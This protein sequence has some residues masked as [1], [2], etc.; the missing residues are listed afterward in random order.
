[1]AGLVGSLAGIIIGLIP[2]LHLNI[3]A[4][5]ILLSPNLETAVFL[6]GALLSSNVFE[7]LGAAYLNV[8]K[9]GEVLLKGAFARFMANGRMATAVKIISYSSI[10]SY[11]LAMALSIFLGKAVSLLSYFLSSYS[12]I[13]LLLASFLII[14]KQKNPL[15]SLAFF[16]L[17]GLLGMLSFNMGLNEP[18]LPL[19]TGMFGIAG[20]IK[21]GG[22]GEQINQMDKT[23]VESDFFDI[24]KA[25]IIGVLSTIAMMLI[26]AISPS[27]IGFFTGNYKD[28]ELKVASMASINI[29]DAIMSLTAFYFINK[30]RSGTVEKIGQAIFI[31]LKEYYLILFCGFFSLII[32][33]ILAP[34]ISKKI[35]NYSKIIGSKW[36]SLGIIIFV[37]LLA[38]YFDSFKG[39]IILALSTLL[40]LF[41]IKKNARP[42]NLMGSLALP[43]I[44]FF[45]GRLF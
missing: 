13:L 9:E 23:A 1:L 14:I 43:T 19:L 44:L 32:A 39:V 38:A 40:G 41:L 5:L 15:K 17:S 45:L 18:F 31:G 24:F 21:K 42:V 6:I 27:Q 26:P 16:L 37:A 28:D 33:C 22:A 34:K 2:G 30:A 7:F 3:F 35:S 29:S 4:Y 12:W 25:S 11:A 20:L 10:I 36:F 8:P